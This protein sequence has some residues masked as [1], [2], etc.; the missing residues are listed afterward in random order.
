LSKLLKHSEPNKLTVLG[1]LTNGKH[2][3]P[4]MDHL[5]CFLP[6][7]LILGY[8]NGLP[9]SHL[10]LAEGLVYTCYQMY[11]QMP[12]FLSPEIVHFNINPNSD[13]DIYVKI[14][15]KHNL[16]RPETV[17][18]LWYMYHFTKNK[19]YQEWGWKI[20]QAFEKYTKLPDGGYTSIDD[21]KNTHDPQPKDMMESFF[22]AET[23]KYFYLLFSDDQTTLS[24]DKWVFN[25]EGHPL[26]ILTT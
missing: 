12:T 2:F 20:F 11:A 7:V 5:V 22:L 26:Q 15:D 3:K 13:A 9:D 10:K 8:H 23:L 14:A 1:E 16:L 24:L 4:K 25:T 19:T 17:E 6:S 21:V 18:S